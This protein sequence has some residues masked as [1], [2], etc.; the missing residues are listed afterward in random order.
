MADVKVQFINQ[1]FGMLVLRYK[2]EKNEIRQQ[3]PNSDIMDLRK[4][5]RKDKPEDVVNFLKL[6]T[7]YKIFV[8]DTIPKDFVNLVSD[9]ISTMTM[10]YSS[11]ES[12]EI[13][14]TIFTNEAFEI[15]DVV[16]IVSRDEKFRD[17][18]VIDEFNPNYYYIITLKDNTTRNLFT[19]NPAF[20]FEF[21]RT[22]NKMKILV[23]PFRDFFKTVEWN[24]PLLNRPL[25]QIITKK[26]NLEPDIKTSREHFDI[27]SKT[28]VLV[29]YDYL[30]YDVNYLASFTDSELEYYLRP[31]YVR[32]YNHLNPPR[33]NKI[34]LRLFCSV[35]HHDTQRRGYFLSYLE[36]IPTAK[37][38]FLDK[39]DVIEIPR[40]RNQL[41]F[42]PVFLQNSLHRLAAS[43][44]SLFSEKHKFNFYQF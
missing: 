10:H 40:I 19:L 20:M 21:T 1:D 36:K 24:N 35:Y 31:Y 16:S 11:I 29:Y 15:A 30:S 8:K 25:C 9:L 43:I 41:T 42:P 13:Y 28:S 6:R 3:Y 27:P 14:S 5:A 17:E 26:I 32:Q 4:L 39:K 12:K 23:P 37:V 22:F 34:S 44:L 7:I 2:D 38:I 33:M 18:T